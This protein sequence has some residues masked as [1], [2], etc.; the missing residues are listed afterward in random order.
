MELTHQARTPR[1][2]DIFVRR[3]VL[4]VVISI[5][6]VLIGTRVALDM[7]V[8]QYPNIES[9]SLEIRTP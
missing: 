3:P 2:T 1:F 8:L 7:P 6:L 5:A 9:A 4:A